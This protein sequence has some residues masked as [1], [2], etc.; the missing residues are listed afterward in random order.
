[1]K[2]IS[3][4]SGQLP[5]QT[6]LV[7]QDVFKT[8][9]TRIQRNN[10]SS[11][12]TSLRRVC[13]TS[14]KNVLKTCFQGSFK[15]NVL[16]LC[17]EDVFKASWR[18]LGR[19]KNVTLKMSSPR[20]MFPGT[21]QRAGNYKITPLTRQCQ[22][23]SIVWLSNETICYLVRFSLKKKLNVLNWYAYYIIKFVYMMLM[24]SNVAENASL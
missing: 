16:Q 24:S 14:S 5:Q 15:E 18:R 9:W 12:K 1:M 4:N 13:N 10:F 8:S 7:F 2:L 23:Q 6:F 3:F 22:L 11:S 17:L 21:N 19:Q 20:R